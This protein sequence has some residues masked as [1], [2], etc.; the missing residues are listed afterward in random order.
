M[1]TYGV[2]GVCG[3]DVW[4]NSTLHALFLCTM[5]GCKPSGVPNKVILYIFPA[6]GSRPDSKQLES[7]H[8]LSGRIVV[9][10][11]Y[12]FLSLNDTANLT[13]KMIVYLQ[14]I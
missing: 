1:H 4:M 13:M 8:G 5:H 6:G 7:L 3:D 9:F 11:M 12:I 2:A 10:L 14:T